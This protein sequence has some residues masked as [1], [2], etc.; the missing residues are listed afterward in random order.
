MEISG[1][2]IFLLAAGFIL[3]LLFLMVLIWPVS[4]RVRYFRENN[5]EVAVFNFFCFGLAYTY[6]STPFKWLLQN[7][8]PVICKNETGAENGEESGGRGGSKCSRPASEDGTNKSGFKS[9]GKVAPE[10]EGIKS[11]LEPSRR[12]TGI[13]LKRI[14][15]KEIRLRVTYGSGDAASTALAVGFFRTVG[16]SLRLWVNSLAGF[17]T[18]RGTGIQPKLEFYPDY[19]RGKLEVYFHLEMKTR[20]Y[21]LAYTLLYLGYHFKVKRRLQKDE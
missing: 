5:E 16:D 11:L 10:G 7:L 17:N 14:I 20:V 8:G 15:W 19:E 1:A 2:F 18:V 12:A 4:I 6:R 9:I 21:L 13:V 3:L